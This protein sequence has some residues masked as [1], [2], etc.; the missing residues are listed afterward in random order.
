[1]RADLRFHLSWFLT[2]S[3]VFSRSGGTEAELALSGRRRRSEAV[4]YRSAGTAGNCPLSLRLLARRYLLGWGRW[5]DNETLGF[6]P[7]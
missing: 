7:T 6:A 5:Q 2:S 4:N 3:C 1:M